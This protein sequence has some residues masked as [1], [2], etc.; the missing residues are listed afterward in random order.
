MQPDHFDPLD[1]AISL[2]TN[3]KRIVMG[4]VL[5]ARYN[6]NIN[7]NRFQQNLWLLGTLIMVKKP[8]P[9]PVP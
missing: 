7:I 6:L 3:P 9:A 2:Y 1:T 8:T 5:T 4:Y